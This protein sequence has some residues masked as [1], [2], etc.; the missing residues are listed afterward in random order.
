M[1]SFL[2]CCI[3]IFQNAAAQDAGNPG[4][5]VLLAPVA[6]FVSVQDKSFT[7]LNYSGG[8]PGAAIDVEFTKLRWQHS[9]NLQFQTGRVEAAGDLDATYKYFNAA[10][11][12]ARP[13]FSHPGAAMQF[14][15]GAALDYVHSARE[16][17]QLINNFNAYEHALSVMVLADAAVQL[18]SNSGVTVISN[19]L[20][21]PAISA[22]AQ[23]VYG[24]DAW[25]VPVEGS[26]TS[27]ASRVL[28]V[29][30]FVLVKNRLSLTHRFSARSQLLFSYLF[31]YM[32]IDDKRAS[33]LSIHQLSLGY[34]FT[35]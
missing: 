13:V 25:D 17:Q 16:Y 24:A 26:S 34:G 11:S 19:R 10:Y 31:S 32:K 5:R 8:V 14:K 23:P 15:I 6:G 18:E 22:V 28:F 21:F 9:L 30:G 35:F 12:L 4:F 2:F 1:R 20:Q 29:P 27:K 3:V 33:V 7:N